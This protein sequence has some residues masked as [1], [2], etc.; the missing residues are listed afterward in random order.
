MASPRAA[1]S[2]HLRLSLVSLAVRIYPAT[3]GGTRVPLNQIHK[4]TGKRI[5]YEKVVPGQG[6]A[7]PEDIVR[8]YEYAKDKYV[9]LDEDEI[10][11]LKLA[12]SKALELTQFVDGDEIEPLY[13]DK[14]YYMAP[15]DEA[16]EEAYVVLR[17]ALKRTGKVGLGQIVMSRRQYIAAI[18]PCGS[19][20]IL[21]TLRYADEVRSARGIFAGLADHEPHE[22][23]IELAEELIRRKTR[24]FDAKAFEDAY[25][26]AL[27]ELIEAKLEDREPETEIVTETGG[28]VVDL[29]E[30]LRKS[31]AA[32]KRKSGGSRKRTS[33][34]SKSTKSATKTSSTK[35]AKASAG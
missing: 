9:L 25:A 23:Q 32:G 15:A 22:E 1:W 20:L 33:G 7:K 27:K 4:P 11:E 16:S 21:E 24:A 3:Q 28:K 17:D 12:S 34:G 13:Y 26:R 30:A 31:V 18:R 35:R 14:P 19:G 10:D 8:G 2:G 5:R 29:M 6:K